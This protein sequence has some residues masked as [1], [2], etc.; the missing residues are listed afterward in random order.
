MFGQ[1]RSE[2]VS[3][4]VRSTTT[5]NDYL[6]VYSGAPQ[7]GGFALA[8]QNPTSGPI[9]LAASA[10]SPIP[11][12]GA[13]FRSSNGTYLYNLLVY[14]DGRARDQILA[15]PIELFWTLSLPGVVFGAGLLGTCL[16]WL[17]RTFRQ[18]DDPVR[19]FYLTLAAWW[20]AASCFVSVL[21]LA[22][23][24]V[25]FFVPVLVLAAVRRL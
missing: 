20:I 7:F 5:L 4:N 24:A 14:P 13:S 11:W 2:Y 25:Y 21:V 18:D 17:A 9:T 16:G 19:V 15:T 22:Q 1:F 3:G 8:S 10:L 6:Q 12:V 23:V